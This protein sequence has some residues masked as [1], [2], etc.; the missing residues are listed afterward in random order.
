MV[1]RKYVA[2]VG[3]ACQ[4]AKAGSIPGLTQLMT[5]DR[6]LRTEVLLL[7][8]LGSAFVGGV[9]D[10]FKSPSPLRQGGRIRS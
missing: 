10:D 4:P 2:L 8:L 6:S 9:I 3:R 7:G 1:T 5:E